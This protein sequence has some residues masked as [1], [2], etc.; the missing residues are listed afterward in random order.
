[1]LKKLLDSLAKTRG[2]TEGELVISRDELELLDAIGNV[3]E[4]ELIDLYLTIHNQGNKHAMIVVGGNELD[5]N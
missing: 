4:Q 2:S 1:M 5:N 3:L